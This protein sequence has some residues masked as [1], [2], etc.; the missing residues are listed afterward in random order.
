MATSP[1]FQNELRCFVQSLLCQVAANVCA[2]HSPK[3][4]YGMVLII[5][6]Q[7]LWLMLIGRIN[8]V[9]DGNPMFLQ[10][11]ARIFTFATKGSISD[12]AV[13]ILSCSG[14]ISLD[15]FCAQISG[16]K[17]EPLTFSQEGARDV[18][19]RSTR[20]RKS[21]DRDQRERRDRVRGEAWQS[22]RR[23]RGRG[24]C[25][26]DRGRCDRDRGNCDRGYG[27]CDTGG[28]VT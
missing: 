5:T 14:C 26:R 9:Q 27:W 28:S 8:I 7:V 21:H 18:W 17:F 23:D 16:V 13:I 25:D 3:Q 20:E 2:A 24:R 10:I 12:N 15:L 4:Q 11:N 1:T 6:S 19:E 22:E